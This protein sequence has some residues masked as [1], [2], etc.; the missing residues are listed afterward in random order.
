MLEMATSKSQV[1]Q[2]VCFWMS[3]IFSSCKFLIIQQSY[4]AVVAVGRVLD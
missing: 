2:D 1:S 4:L 3:F